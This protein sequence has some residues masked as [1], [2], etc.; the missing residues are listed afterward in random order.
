MVSVTLVSPSSD[1]RDF[2]VHYGDSKE[3]FSSSN[4][5]RFQK[6]AM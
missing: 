5:M 4:Q 6:K 3:A 1:L 2:L